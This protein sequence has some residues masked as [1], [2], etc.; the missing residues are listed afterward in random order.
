[1][2]LLGKVVRIKE[3]VAFTDVD[4][5]DETGVMTLKFPDYKSAPTWIKRGQVVRVYAVPAII[6][7]KKCGRI[8]RAIH[9]S[10][11]IEKEV[12]YLFK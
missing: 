12:I 3:Y 1:M 4:V 9:I 5:E 2:V 11:D 8:L 6:D 10:K 7:G